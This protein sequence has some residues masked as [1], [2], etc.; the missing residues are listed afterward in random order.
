MVISMVM[1][2]SVPEPGLLA[3]LIDSTSL[4]EGQPKLASS[5]LNSIVDFTI[6]MMLCNE[7]E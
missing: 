5:Q 6:G 7:D 4:S 2:R 1:I 3:L